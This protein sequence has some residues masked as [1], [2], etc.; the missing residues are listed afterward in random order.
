MSKANEE[1][2]GG[3]TYSSEEAK[4]FATDTIMTINDDLD[5]REQESLVFNGLKYSQAYEYN[6]RKAINYAPP[7]S[8]KDDREVSVGIVHEKIVSFVAIFLKYVFKHNIKAY[9]DGELIP[10][11]GDVYELGI[12]YSQKVERL[13]NK[14]ALI[15]WE[16]FSQ[17]DAWVLEDWQVRNVTNPQ[18]MLEGQV[19]DLSEMDYTYE[20]LEQLEYQDGDEVQL[21]RAVSVILD[22]RQVILGDPELDAGVQEQPR[23]TIEEKMSRADAEMMF[24]SLEM[25]EQVPKEREELT[26]LGLQDDNT[27]FNSNRLENPGKEVIVHRFM[28]KE[29]NR[30]NIFV[31]GVMMLPYK[32]PFTIFY[33]RNNYPITQFSAERMTGSAYSRSIPAKT[34]FNADFLDWALKKM[35]LKFEQG[36]EPAII[37]KGKY[38]LSRDMFRAGN[39]THGVNPD[40]YTKADPDNKG[41]VQA[42]FSFFGLLKEIIESQTVNQTTSGEVSASATAT[43]I[44]ITDQNQQKKLAYLLDAMVNGYFDLCMRRAETIECKYTRAQGVT[45][46]D[47]KE[48]KVYQDFSIAIAGVQNIVSFDDSLQDPEFN[49]DQKKN[50]LF[51]RSYKAK[52]KGAPTEYYLVDPAYIRS[53]KLF[54]DIEIRPELIKDSQLQLIQMFDEF[55]QT[56]NIFGRNDQGGMVN[57]EELKKEYLQVSGRSDDF[58]VAAQLAQDPELM[59]A[60]AA[61]GQPSPYNMGSFG[62]T[63]GTP[64]PKVSDAVKRNMVGA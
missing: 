48:R 45:I 51:Q 18:P 9:Y 27:L 35:A 57:M 41:L 31:N 5:K 50:E 23:I 13:A 3:I 64:T 40:D 16:V 61:G 36:I 42:E 39:V 60:L 19:L 7:R 15:Y 33:P 12:T 22:G 4:K 28:D 43:E 44:A 10:H 32:T 11:M 6:Q 53:G 24:G 14:I 37:A 26:A 2:S 34:K 21:R 63:S 59:Q 58:F 20:F 54:L 52:E 29:N 25:W 46:V 1:R 56:I 17:G 62:K 38:T 55:T 47:G 30:Y 8:K 49:A